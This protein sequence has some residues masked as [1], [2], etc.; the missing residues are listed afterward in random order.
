MR[1]LRAFKALS[2][3]NSTKVT[4]KENL[5]VCTKAR[6]YRILYVIRFFYL[7]KYL[8]IN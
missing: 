7:C 1:M 3:Q 4:C 5:Q 8:N 6:N 2:Y